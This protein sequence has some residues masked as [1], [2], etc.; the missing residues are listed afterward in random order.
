PIPSLPLNLPLLK[1]ASVVGVFWGEYAKREPQANTAML[2]TLVQWMA[3]GR[4]KPVIDRTL[5]MSELPQALALMGQ[6]QVKG[7]LVLLNSD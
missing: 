4:I 2:Q 7:K 6:R 1:G 5:P 3:Q